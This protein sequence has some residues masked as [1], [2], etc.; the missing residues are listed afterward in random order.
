ML[1]EQDTNASHVVVYTDGSCLGNPGR[2]G[3]AAR[4]ECAGTV[5]FL[6]GGFAL[7]TNNRM[8]IYAVISA[9]SALT[10][11]CTVVLYTDS[12]YVCD[13]IE[14]GWLFGWKKKNW[15]KSDKKPVLNRD[16]WEQ[17]YPLLAKH[18]VTFKWV[19]AHVGHKHNEEV[20]TL[21]REQASKPGNPPDEGFIASKK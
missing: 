7:T 1:N 17:V 3:W 15:I 6:Q 12:R 20:D 4:L 19:E 2:G 9:L 8:E 11:K 14:K 21:A 10:R 13:A 16:L 18:S 5:K